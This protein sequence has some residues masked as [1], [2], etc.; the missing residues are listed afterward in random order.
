MIIN[1]AYA[2][3]LLYEKLLFCPCKLTYGSE[4]AVR[5]LTIISEYALMKETKDV[6]TTLQHPI[7]T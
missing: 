7:C 2:I 1:N 4:K 6:G 5:K 3:L